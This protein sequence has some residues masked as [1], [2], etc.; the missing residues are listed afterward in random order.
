M[1][2]AGIHHNTPS[3]FNKPPKF[4]ME[5][6]EWKNP[7]LDTVTSDVRSGVLDCQAFLEQSHFGM[8]GP[9]AY[10]SSTYNRLDKAAREDFIAALAS[11]RLKAESSDVD[12]RIKLVRS[13]LIILERMQPELGRQLIQALR[14]KPWNRVII[15]AI[16]SL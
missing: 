2:A 6:K 5:P 1:I 10:I 3:L 8:Q 7:V 12:F 4:G 14:Q 15:E 9:A 16:V 13:A 11:H